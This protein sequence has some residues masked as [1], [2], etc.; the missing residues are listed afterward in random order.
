MESDNLQKDPK[1][2]MQLAKSGDAEAFG[3]LYELYFTPVFRYIYFRVKDK[4]TANDLTQT[5]FLKVFSALPNF[6]EQNKSPLAYF[7]T[8]A[9][10]TVI[11]YW[12]TKKE[13]LLNVPT[14]VFEKIPDKANNPLELIEKE[15]TSKAIRRAIHE[16]TEIQQEV[17]MLKFINDISNKEIA[18]LLGKTEESV[19]QLQCRAL[20]TLQ[21]IFKNQNLI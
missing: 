14:N 10:N 7:F 1:I 17:I 16:L 9:R 12:R 5:V 13:I 4:E 18:A 3:R 2:L 21:R 11:D 20:K 6:R 15:E 19:R 8:V